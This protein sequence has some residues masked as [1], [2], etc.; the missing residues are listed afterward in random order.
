[1]SAWKAD[2]LPLG[3]AR[4]TCLP[5][6]AILPLFPAN[7]NDVRRLQ[8]HALQLLWAHLQRGRAQRPHGKPSPLQPL[9]EIHAVAAHVVQLAEAPLALDRVADRRVFV[10]FLPADGD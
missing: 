8:S 4:I 2:A 10:R 1:M 5:G 3:D 9:D 7:E 6:E